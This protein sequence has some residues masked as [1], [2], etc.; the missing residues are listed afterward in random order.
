MEGGVYVSDTL[1]KE[2]G[3]LTKISLKGLKEGYLSDNELILISEHICHCEG[4]ADALANSFDDIE[5]VE[6]P[7]GFEAEILSKIKKKKENNNQFIFYSLRVAM[8]ASIALMFVFSSTLN[9]VANT[10]AKTLNVSPL[11]LSTVNT[12]NR[13]LNDFSQKLVNMEVFNNEKGK[14]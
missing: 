13:S 4:C 6:A 11:S 9:F 10:E 2:N 5:L 14:K 3:H 7:L 1:F 8:A 12:I